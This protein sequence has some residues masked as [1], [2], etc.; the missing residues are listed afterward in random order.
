MTPSG[1]P[2][3]RKKRRPLLYR[4]PE[5]LAADRAQPVDVVEGEKDAD[6]LWSLGLIATC[7]DGGGGRAKWRRA[8]SLPLRGRS[9]IIVPDNDL[10]GA[11][12]AED[13]ARRLSRLAGSVRVLKLPGLP[14]KGDVSDW[15]DSEGT[16]E[17]LTRLS[18]TAVPWTP[19]PLPLRISSDVDHWHGLAWALERIIPAS[20][21][22]V[23]KLLLTTFA[24]LVGR[25]SALSQQDLAMYLG[26]SERRVRQ[27]VA[28]LKERGLLDVRRHGR[29]NQYSIR[30]WQL[31]K[32]A[33][34]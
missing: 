22:T 8:H 29:S 14:R 9:V 25:R 16:P 30:T 2:W 13:V 3:K 6:R 32:L 5:L 4:L 19:E 26:V 10:T 1:Q 21:S 7:N 12:H 31:E 28:G 23:E 15:L 18:A 27:L 33:R 24:V 20:I 17:E 11:E 34:S